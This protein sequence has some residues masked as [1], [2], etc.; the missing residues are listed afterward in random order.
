[1]IFWH[2]VA[3]LAQY[4][5]ME[6]HPDVHLTHGRALCISNDD[7]VPTI[8]PATHA[9]GKFGRAGSFC[10]GCVGVAADIVS[11]EALSLLEPATPTTSRC[12]CALRPM[13]HGAV[14]ET[15]ADRAIIRF[16]PMMR[17]PAFSGILYGGLG[18]DL[19]VE[20]ALESFF[21][22]EG[23][24]VPEA[25]RLHRMVRRKARRA[26]M[27]GRVVQPRSRSRA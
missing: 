9:N 7:P 14:G 18:W 12:D 5:S 13:A 8:A 15:H 6:E 1:M 27:L 22:N 2:Q 17:S 23:A 11:T 4:H 10:K 19:H 20:A 3:F 16:H 26:R 24:S 21:A 25:K